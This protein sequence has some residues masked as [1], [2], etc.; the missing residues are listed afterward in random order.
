MISASSRTARTRV[1]QTASGMN[2]KVTG[3]VLWHTE[4]STIQQLSMKLFTISE[5]FMKTQG[6]QKQLN[7]GAI[8]ATCSCCSL[9]HTRS[10]ETEAKSVPLMHTSHAGM[11]I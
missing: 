11:D 3:E 7:A 6:G 2:S 9:D 4:R 10:T 5:Q 1:K 8:P